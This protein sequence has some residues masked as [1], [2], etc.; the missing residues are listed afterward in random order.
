MT[1]RPGD[2]LPDVVLRDTRGHDVALATLG[3]EA[4]LIIFLR[5]LT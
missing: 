3:G 4:T 5:H 1:I 2:P